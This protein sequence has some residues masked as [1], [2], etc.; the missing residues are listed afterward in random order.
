MGNRQ[1]NF[2]ME[3]LS[4]MKTIKSIFLVLFLSALFGCSVMGSYGTVVPD[5][6]TTYAFEA[7]QMDPGMKYYFIGSESYPRALIGLKK[8]YV[9]DNNLWKLIKPD[10]GVLQRMVQSMQKMASELGVKQYGFA[11]NDPKGRSI[12]VWYSPL[13]ISKSIEMQGDNR[14]IVY[15]P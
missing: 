1:A 11:M 8:E 14:V 5:G 15:A 10:S 12:G 2:F 4:K 6:E 13:K 9:L 7:F 3:G